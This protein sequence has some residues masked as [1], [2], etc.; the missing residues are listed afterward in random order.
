MGHPR[1]VI[2]GDLVA[3]AR[4]HMYPNGTH[5]VLVL[6]AQPGHAPVL[7]ERT[8]GIGWGA[9]WAASQAALA[10]RKGHQVT[11]HGHAIRP[12]RFEKQTVMR[13]EGVDHIE[14]AAARAHHEPKSAATAA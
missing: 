9:S 6:I 3:H 12:S 7:A 2:T 14:H 13:L 4:N 5:A 1:I 10:M 8:F 11:A